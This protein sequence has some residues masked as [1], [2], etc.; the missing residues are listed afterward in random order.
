[1]T[2]CSLWSQTYSTPHNVTAAVLKLF[3]IPS[4]TATPRT[5]TVPLEPLKPLTFIT[6]T[7]FHSLS[8]SMLKAQSIARPIFR[9]NSTITR[10]FSTSFAK[11]V[12]VGD[13]IPSVELAETTPGTKINLEKEL[14][15]GKGLI[16]GV[17]AAFSM[18]SRGYFIH[19]SLHL[20]SSSSTQGAQRR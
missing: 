6:S 13:S 15:S 8:I 9:Y 16:I 12:K 10:S 2:S 7:L 18:S 20:P 17:P 5:S 14:A 11:M 3:E 19:H 4:K 1:M